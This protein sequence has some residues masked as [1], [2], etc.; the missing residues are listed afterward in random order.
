MYTLDEKYLLSILFQNKLFYTH[1]EEFENLFVF[2]MK[3]KYGEQFTKVKPW[4]SQGD[5]KNDGCFLQEKI[6]YQV[7]GP[8][9]LAKSQDH[10][11]RK[12]KED[13]KGAKDHWSDIKEFYFVVNDKYLGIPPKGLE[14]IQKIKKELSLEKAGF[15][16]SEDLESRTLALDQ[17][18]LMKIL[19]YIPSFENLHK[20]KL[21]A[22]RDIIVKIMKS[23]LGMPPKSYIA[24]DWDQFST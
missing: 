15:I 3:A 6:L 18:T 19:G 4:G 17:L 10:F 8:E 22:L 9:D 13:S 2:I 20:I 14:T 21:E 12:L 1:G 16:T 23:P 24:P 5:K 7:Y 11:L